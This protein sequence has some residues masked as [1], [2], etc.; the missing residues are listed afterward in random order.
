MPESFHYFKNMVESTIF[1]ENLLEKWERD[2][3]FIEKIMDAFNMENWNTENNNVFR[4]IKEHNDFEYEK[5]TILNVF[6][7]KIESVNSLLEIAEN[8]N[9]REK[10][11]NYINEIKIIFSEFSKEE[12]KTGNVVLSNRDDTKSA[13]EKYNDNIKKQKENNLHITY[14]DIELYDKKPFDLSGR[15]ISD[16]HFTAME[17]AGNNLSI[18]YKCL[19]EINRL[20]LMHKDLYEE[21]EF[22]KVINT[23]YMFNRKLPIS[24]LRC[25]PYTA[26]M[27]KSKYPLC[28]WLSNVGDYGTEYIYAIYFDREGNIGQCELSLHG[29]DGIGI[30]YETK[31]RR[32]EGGLYILRINKTLYSPPYGTTTIY[33]HR[34]SIS[35]N[36]KPKIKSE[37]NLERYARECN[38][39]I[40]RE[41]RKEQNNNSK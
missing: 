32:G 22:P 11:Y 33:H 24:H 4:D 36:E 31:I 9:D 35:A 29:S 30:S 14:E 34:D 23:E 39:Y 27:R 21:T 5:R 18:A 17:L 20:L 37:Y 10:F 7:S 15:L 13:Y 6:R 16:E 8:T 25:I 40:M 26:T 41:E 28:L 38:A 1:L 12:I 3:K 2:M 19:Q